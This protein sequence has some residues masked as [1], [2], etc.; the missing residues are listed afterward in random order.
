[1]GK[2]KGMLLSLD[3]HKAF[4]SLSWD[5]LLQTLERFGFGHNFLTIVKTL[6]SDPIAKLSIRGDQSDY[7]AIR[8]GTRQGCPLSPLLF[9]LALEPLAIKLRQNLNIQGIPC[10][11]RVHKCF[12]FADDILMYLSSPLASIPNLLRELEMFTTLSGLRINQSKSQ[13]LNLTIDKATINTLKSDFPFTWQED[14]LPY[15]GIH[16]TT[17]IDTLYKHNFPPLYKKLQDDLT[18]WATNP[19]SWFGRLNSVKMNILPRL[20]YLFR[21]YPL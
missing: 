18:R 12:L 15:L 19:P 21:S 9:I 2:R 3:M 7:I 14:A 10:G 13:A 6:C 1:M 11:G 8:R 4:D 20:L 16:L 5:Y 17:S